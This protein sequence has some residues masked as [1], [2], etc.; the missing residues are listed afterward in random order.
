MNS[1]TGSP[2]SLVSSL[3]CRGDA[4]TMA[5]V[6]AFTHMHMGPGLLKHSLAKVLLELF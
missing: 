2:V 5:Q 4:V 6:R 1:S 3:V